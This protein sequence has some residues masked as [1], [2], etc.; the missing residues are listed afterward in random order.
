M[1]VTKENLYFPL[2]VF[3]TAVVL[4]VALGVATFLFFFALRR[5]SFTISKKFTAHNI[6]I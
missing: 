2:P 6:F 5:F 1:D 4:F 3:R